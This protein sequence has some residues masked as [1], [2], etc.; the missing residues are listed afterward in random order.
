MNLNASSTCPPSLYWRSP[1]PLRRCGEI[2]EH[3]TG[4][5]FNALADAYRGSGGLVRGDDLARMLADRGVG[6]VSSLARLIE[7]RH[8]FS[9]RWQAELWLPL[10]QFGRSDPSAPPPLQPVLHEL[11]RVFGAWDVATWFVHCNAL[12]GG[13]RPIDALAS[14]LQGVIDAARGDRL[15]AGRRGGG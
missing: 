4:S 15:A 7:R 3:P 5:D 2:G 8:V 6:D 1:S 9:F 14:N 12:L 10:F 13:A 11:D